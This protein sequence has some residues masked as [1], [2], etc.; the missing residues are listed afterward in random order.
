[1]IE[2]LSLAIFLGWCW[3]SKHKDD[4]EFDRR[5]AQSEFNQRQ[6]MKR[7]E[8]DPDYM[9]E[10]LDVSDLLNTGKRPTAD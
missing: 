3:W 7:L 6:L 2:L 10:W 9:A 8:E 1:M 5:R 4:L